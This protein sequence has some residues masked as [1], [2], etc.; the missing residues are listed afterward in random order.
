MGPLQSP[1]TPKTL[2]A[3]MDFSESYFLIARTLFSTQ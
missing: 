2:D 3:V 1:P